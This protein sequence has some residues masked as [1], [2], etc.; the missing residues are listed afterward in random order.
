MGE[1]LSNPTALAAQ[2]L[3]TFPPA[4]RK[5][6]LRT[7]H[8]VVNK[9]NIYLTVPGEEPNA[10]DVATHSEWCKQNGLAQELHAL[11]EPLAP[12]KCDVVFFYAC[13]YADTNERRAGA[14]AFPGEIMRVDFNSFIS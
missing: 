12:E 11:G 13:M 10:V 2:T 7:E 3:P 5:V 14:F 8:R 6:G 9:A 4:G 1:H